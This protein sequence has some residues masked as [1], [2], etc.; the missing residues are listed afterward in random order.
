MLFSSHSATGAWSKHLLYFAKDVKMIYSLNRIVNILHEI[1]HI[2]AD[3]SESIICIRHTYFSDEWFCLWIPNS[4]SDHPTIQIQASYCQQNNKPDAQPYKGIRRSCPVSWSK[5]KY[6]YPP[7]IENHAGTWG[8]VSIWIWMQFS[9]H[10]LLF[11]ILSGKTITQHLSHC[12][13]FNREIILLVTAFVP[14]KDPGTFTLSLSS[15]SPVLK[16][17]TSYNGFWDFKKSISC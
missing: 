5:H 13:T 9:F 7:I 11:Q 1:S 12:H 16:I 4:S 14:P 8:L 3:P 2:G 17:S 6:T 15:K 10:F